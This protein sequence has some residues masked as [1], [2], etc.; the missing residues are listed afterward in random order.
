MLEELH[1]DLDRRGVRLGLAELHFEARDL[2]V[3]AGVIT[4][5]GPEMVFEDLEDALRAFRALPK[6]ETP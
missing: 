4:S 2:L 6:E 1:A 5:I 3:R